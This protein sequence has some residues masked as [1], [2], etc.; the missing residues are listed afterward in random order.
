M[1]PEKR[2][3][4]LLA[5]ALNPSED[6]QQAQG[7]I[8]AIK[9]DVDDTGVLDSSD[10]VERFDDAVGKLVYINKITGLSKYEGPSV[11]E[12][13]VPCVSDV[14][15]MA[16]S[17]I[18]RNGF[19][20][21]CYPFQAELVLPFLPRSRAERVLSSGLDEEVSKLTCPPC[22]SETSG[23]LLVLVDQHAAHERVRLESL[24]ADSYEDDP[25]FLGQKQL[26][27]SN[28]SPPLEIVVTEEELRLLRSCP[29]FLRGLG[30]EMKFVETEEPRVLVGKVPV[31]FVEREAS[32]LRHGRHT[33]T[34]DIVLEYIQE[35]LELLRSAGRVRG[36]LP[37]TV[38]KVLASQ[39]CHGAVKFNASLSREECCSLIGSLSTCKLPFQCAHGRPSM[40][41]L[42]DLLHLDTE[43]QKSPKPN[44]R[45]L[46][47]RY[48]AWKRHGDEQGRQEATRQ[49]CTNSTGN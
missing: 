10:W 8:Q 24:T 46:R 48:Q 17:V 25:E 1:A 31:C 41:P 44:L 32:E 14:T 23:N 4:P 43:Q 47:L 13:Q 39:A 36:T 3:D 49:H 21:R 35:Q 33:V 37:L 34:R 15:T 18:S 20:Y 28:V 2:L 27:S 19:E 26:R 38:L 42:A 29:Q 12:T 40:V 22:S 30:L 9:K 6:V 16:V 5:E 7:T 45:K 11:E